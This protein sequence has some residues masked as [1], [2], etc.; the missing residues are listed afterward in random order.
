MNID[1]PKPAAKPNK[2]RTINTL[3]QYQVKRLWEIEQLHVPAHRSGMSVD[4]QRLHEMT[5]GQAA[6]YIRKMTA[7]LHQLGPKPKKQRTRKAAVPPQSPGA[8][9]P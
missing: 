8:D 9:K 6:K 2:S 4:P 1:V 5:E 3:L 7:K